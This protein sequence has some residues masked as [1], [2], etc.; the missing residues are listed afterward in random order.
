[1]ESRL[2]SWVL[3]AG[4]CGESRDGHCQA[5]GVWSI[6]ALRMTLRTGFEHPTL[7]EKHY[8]NTNPQNF[9]LLLK[10]R[11]GPGEPNT[12]RHGKIFQSFQIIIVIIATHVV[13]LYYTYLYVYNYIIT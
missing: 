8:D 4:H 10:T 13:I 2:P 5:P 6:F 1:M 9:T 11:Q 7:W 12:R 3:K